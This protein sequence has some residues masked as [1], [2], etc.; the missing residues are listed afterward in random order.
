MTAD[1][2]IFQNVFSRTL[3]E[4]RTR[5]EEGRTCFYQTTFQIWYVFLASC[6]SWIGSG[7]T[8]QYENQRFSEQ[9]VA[10]CK[11]QVGQIDN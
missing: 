10:S 9:Q 11:L 4:I 3:R 7:Y 6:L 8:I 2:G 1:Q 5:T